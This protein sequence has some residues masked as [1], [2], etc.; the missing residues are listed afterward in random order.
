MLKNIGK[1]WVWDYQ[2][3]NG[4]N[5]ASKSIISVG[6]FMGALSGVYIWNYNM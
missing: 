6:K 5:F 4:K 1:A 2:S 3:G